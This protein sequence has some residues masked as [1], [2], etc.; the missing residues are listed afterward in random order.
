[1]LV[2]GKKEMAL[3]TLKE[4]ARFN[5]KEMPDADLEVPVSAHSS[6]GFAELFNGKKMAIMTLVQ[7]YAW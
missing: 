3:D 5:K 4:V 2:T 7:C 1:M 6:K